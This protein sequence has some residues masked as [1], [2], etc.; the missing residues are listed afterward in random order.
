MSL[1]VEQ[2]SVR[3]A[4]QLQPNDRQDSFH[5]EEKDFPLLESMTAPPD[6]GRTRSH[7]TVLTGVAAALW[8]SPSQKSVSGV[9]KRA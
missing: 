6:N 3:D 2:P 8:G 1:A 7:G 9:S 4:R 5:L